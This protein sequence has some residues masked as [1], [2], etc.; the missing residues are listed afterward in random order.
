M[1]HVEHLGHRQPPKNAGLRPV[2][3]HPSAR[4]VT[5][6]RFGAV[7]VLEVCSSGWHPVGMC[8]FFTLSVAS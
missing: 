2:T 5:G 1:N 3:G 7:P 8:W 6:D 4:V